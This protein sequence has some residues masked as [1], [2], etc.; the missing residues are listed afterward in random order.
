MDGVA[1]H[2]RVRMEVLGPLRVFDGDGQEVTPDGALQ[3]RLLAMLVLRRD[4]VL[5]VGA[6]IDALWPAEA[7]RDP[8]AAL[9]NQVFRLRRQLP[10]GLVESVGDGYRIASSDLDV[11]ADRLADAVRAGPDGED[12]LAVV[13]AVLERWKGPAYP[14]LDDNDE[15]RLE[16]ARL[17]DLRVR[18]ME[19]RAECR[20]DTGDTGRAIAELAALVE[21]EPLRER[22]RALLMTALGRS[23]RQAEALRVYDDFRRL[24]GDELGIEPS[25]PLI[26]QHADLLAGAGLVAWTAPSRLPRPATS[27]LGRE[28]LLAE[29]TDLVGAHPVVTLV[30]PGGVGKT[31]L[32]TEVGR[33]LQADQRDRSVVLCELASA[34]AAFAVDAI[35]A[36]LTIEARPGLSIVER[37]TTV[38]ADSEVV[39]ILD[40]CE[41]VLD[42]VAE[43]VEH[44]VAA[45]P[46]VTVLA[47][48][49]ER[50]RVPGERVVTVPSLAWEGHGPAVQLF[51]ERARAVAPAFEPSSAELAGVYDIVRRLDGLPLAIELAAARLHTHDVAEVAAGLDR[52]FDL[53]TSGSRTSTRHGSLSAA[54]SWS[55]GLLD[56]TLQETFADLSVFAGPFTA[57]DAAAICGA[58]LHA[59]TEALTQLA[60]RSLVMRSADRRFMLLETL[61]AFGAEQLAASGRAA[62]VRWRHARHQIEWIEWADGGLLDGR[63]SC[64]Q[65]DAAISELRAALDW[66][67]DQGDVEAAGRL[68]APF[69]DYGFLH[70]RPDVLMWAE[71]VVEADPE[72]RSP[73]AA[74]ALV[75]AAYGAW[76]GGRASEIEELSRRALHVAEAAGGPIPPEVTTICG[77]AALFEGRLADAVRWYGRAV[78]SAGDDRAQWL[79]AVG[80]EVLARAYGDDPAAEPLAAR[81]L[82]A[83]GSSVSPHAAYSWYCAG[84]SDL[85]TN[86]DR[87][88][89]RFTRALQLAEASGA[90][91]V[92][93]LAGASRASLDARL[94]DPRAAAAEYR[95]LIT[96]WQRAGVWSTQWTMLRSVAILLERLGRSRDAAVLEGAVRATTA[97]HR[98]FG[99]DE[100]ALAELGVR[101][102]ARLGDE[103]YEAARREGAVLDGDAAVEHA[104][105]AL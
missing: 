73:W 64:A 48:S 98:I 38:L 58:D 27:L 94:G 85:A 2:G 49:R 86:P 55:H 50:L 15:G 42:P 23:G 29:L 83:V 97:G 87:A 103:G 54:V 25:P 39:M 3:R 46:N 80:A 40:N 47:T 26:A 57:E 89:D 53:L 71:R 28:A 99:A 7:P 70:Q 30:G 20:L 31:R 11:D 74:P 9:Q 61:R 92:T 56:A 68:V 93:G 19:L 36:A 75:V 13:D 100:N 37:I 14:D 17:D 96:H 90:S 76:L 45:C 79:I 10:P 44:V 81:L 77:S 104:L 8:V 34:T 67:L 41:H 24:L 12:A 21:A 65:I 62:D 60:E 32:A 59:I 95:R 78:E 6:A 33:L 4:H 43:L 63:S 72:H 16:S 22:P 66:L 18:A 52:R 84:E 91:V 88:R 1:Q 51:V 69:L 102:R 101:L 105:R 5:T 82:E 35:A